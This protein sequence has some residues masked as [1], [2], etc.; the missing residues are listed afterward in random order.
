M[1]ARRRAKW[2]AGKGRCRSPERAALDLTARLELR[3]VDWSST[4][5]FAHPA[6]NQGYIRLNLQGRERDGIVAPEDAKALMDEIAAGIHTFREL[7]GSP[8]V[9][10]VDRVADRFGAGSRA[11]QLPDLI[12]RWTNTP[13]T[14]LKGLRSERFGTVSRRGVGSGRSGNHTEGDAWA[15]VIP[16]SSQPVATSRPPR[17][18]DIAATVA[19][20]GGLDVTHMAGEPLLAR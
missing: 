10:S 16:G 1:A 13:A 2:V 17:L 3:G 4:R 9:Q 19:A 5:A 11:D 8:A 14:R 7:D 15:L 18:E 20:V 6:E 12:V